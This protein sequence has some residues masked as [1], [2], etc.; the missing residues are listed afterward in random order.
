MPAVEKGTYDVEVVLTK[1]RDYGIVQLSL[2]GQKLG[3]PI[4]LYNALDVITTG[5]IT[6]ENRELTAGKHKLTISIVGAHPK[7]VKAYMVGLDYVR[8]SPR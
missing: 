1:A 2:D 5:V 7:A 4:D 8:L 3:Q 6:F